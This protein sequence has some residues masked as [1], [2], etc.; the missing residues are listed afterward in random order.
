MN[1]RSGQ[2]QNVTKKKTGVNRNEVPTENATNLMNCKEIKQNS[3]MESLLNKITH[4]QITQTPGNRF[5]PCYEKR[6]TKLSC[7]KWNN[8]RQN[9]AMENSVKIF[10]MH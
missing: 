2:F 9:A 3:V 7:D 10:W 4:I 1:A 6:E 5:W 8:R